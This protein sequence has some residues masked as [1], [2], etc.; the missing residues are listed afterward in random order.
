MNYQTL[1]LFGQ[2]HLC[3]HHEP[4]WLTADTADPVAAQNVLPLWLPHAHL[5]L[6]L[7]TM[8]ATE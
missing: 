8:R 2:H 6:G 5:L 3:E 7:L 4:V 1:D